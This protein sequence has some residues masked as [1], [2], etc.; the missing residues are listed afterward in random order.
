MIPRIVLLIALSLPI[1]PA[2]ASAA[3]ALPK[4]RAAATHPRSPRATTPRDRVLGFWHGTSDCVEKGGPC[5]DEIVR[6]DFRNVPGKPDS[7]RLEA[8]KIVDGRFVS[9]GGLNG[10]WEAASRSVICEYSNARTHVL[11]RF[12]AHGE[13]LVGTL[14]DLPGGRLLRNVSCVRGPGREPGEKR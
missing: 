2:N 14:V 13:S 9:M 1:V 7:I 6:Y 4:V 12:E 5:H 8:Y 3:I 11:W 10:A